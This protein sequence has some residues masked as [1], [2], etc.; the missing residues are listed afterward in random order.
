MALKIFQISQHRNEKKSKNN[1]ER[2]RCINI[3]MKCGQT[4]QLSA[5]HMILKEGG[6]EKNGGRSKFFW[7]ETSTLG[8]WIFS[9]IRTIKKCVG[10]QHE[11][12]IC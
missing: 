6:R 9:L 3:D 4:C 10:G 7:I 5:G 1:Y 8:D 2:K 12:M 11:K